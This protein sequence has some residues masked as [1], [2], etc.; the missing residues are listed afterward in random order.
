MK[1]TDSNPNSLLHDTPEIQDKLKTIGQL[2]K[3]LSMETKNLVSKD[4]PFQETI[5]F[6]NLL[7]LTTGTYGQK[8]RQKRAVKNKKKEIIKN[9]HGRKTAADFSKS[10]QI[11]KKYCSFTI[12]FTRVYKGRSFSYLK[13][14]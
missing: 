6:N 12:L 10:D 4:W 3:D 7:E 11:T 8:D 1:F 13:I 9:L 14:C 2:G 5:Y